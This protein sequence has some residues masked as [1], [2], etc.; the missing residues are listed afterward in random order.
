MP[1]TSQEDTGEPGLWDIHPV[2]GTWWDPS[3]ASNLDVTAIRL[4]AT[5]DQGRF[6]FRALQHL[7]QLPLEFLHGDV[8]LCPQH[9]A[10]PGVQTVMTAPVTSREASGANPGAVSASSA[11]S[12]LSA[13]LLAARL[14]PDQLVV[15]MLSFSRHSLCPVPPARRTLWE[16]L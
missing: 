11:N 10:A 3:F 6:L 12:L 13:V 4:T 7:G 8:F 16:R 9:P 5:R 2:L 1:F 14:L 15:T